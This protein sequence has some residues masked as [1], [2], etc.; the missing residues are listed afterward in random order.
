[1]VLSLGFSFRAFRNGDSEPS[2]Y[3]VTGASIFFDQS[4]KILVYSFF[5]ELTMLFLPDWTRK[6][7]YSFGI[8]GGKENSSWMGKESTRA[9]QENWKLEFNGFVFK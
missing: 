8:R 2:K 3:I 1:M 7:T 9:S 6:G 5:Y 4:Y